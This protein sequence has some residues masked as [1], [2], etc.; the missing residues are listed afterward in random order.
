MIFVN[1]NVKRY[2]KRNIQIKIASDSGPDASHETP[3][4]GSLREYNE[5]LSNRN[6]ETRATVACLSARVKSQRSGTKRHEETIFV[7]LRDYSEVTSNFNT[8]EATTFV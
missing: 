4:L 3:I 8:S 5:D 2:V 1:R 7:L 6:T